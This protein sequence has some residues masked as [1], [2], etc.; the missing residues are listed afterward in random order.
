MNPPFSTLINRQRFKLLLIVLGIPLLLLTRFLVQTLEHKLDPDYGELVIRDSSVVLRSPM[1]EARVKAP[2]DGW[3]LAAKLWIKNTA[4]YWYRKAG[5]DEQTLCRFAL[6]DDQRRVSM[7]FD[8][9]RVIKNCDCANTI[10]S[11]THPLSK[12]VSGLVSPHRT[13]MGSLQLSVKIYDAPDRNAVSAP[14]GS[15]RFNTG[16]LEGLSDDEIRALFGH[17]LGHIVMAHQEEQNAW[18]TNMRLFL[19]KLSDGTKTKLTDPL[20]HLVSK[21]HELKADDFSFKWAKHHDYDLRAHRTVLEKLRDVKTAPG[22]PTVDERAK[23]IQ[24]KLDWEN[25]C[26]IF[27]QSFR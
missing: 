19:F 24:R 6:P 20:K 4:V 27:S 26:R 17:E 14:D 11:P 3:Q 7:V 10:L 8:Y 21:D 16:I 2:L 5:A 22:Y 1:P 23:R 13:E 25:F 15:I 18:D 12:R 9:R